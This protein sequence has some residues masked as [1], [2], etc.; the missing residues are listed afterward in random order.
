M[1]IYQAILFLH[2]LGALGLFVGLAFEWL[3]LRRINNAASNVQLKEWIN[4]LASLKVIFSISGITLLLSG[5]YMSVIT[6]GGP[7]WIVIAFIGL[8][9]S[10][11]NGS[12]ITG[13]KIEALQKLVNSEDTTQLPNIFE[14]KKNQKLFSHFQLRAAISLSI[15]FL[16]TFKPEII[17]S[18]VVFVLAIILGSLPVLLAKRPVK[19]SFAE[20]E[21]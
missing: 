16:M 2:I 15:I 1:I 5:T 7:A 18:I 9:T 10:A 6:W 21:N 4:F 20:S 19:S 12:V 14:E 8:V 13:K 3:C 11:I 17:G